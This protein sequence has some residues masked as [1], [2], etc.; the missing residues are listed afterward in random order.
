MYDLI[1][2]HKKLV[3]LVLAVI[4]LPFAFF[5][6][7]SYFTAGD[8]GGNFATVG[9]QP[10]TEQEFTLALQSRQNELQRMAGGRMDPALLDSSE[11]RFAVL[12]GI[13]RQ[14]LLVGQAVRSG[15]LVSDQQLQQIIG[16]Q[17]EFQEDG[18]FSRVRYETLLR[19]QGM[20]PVGF[21]N[22][23]RRDLMVERVSNAYR[24]TAI[25]P[26][27]VTERLLRI[28]AQQREV[29]Q[30]V[31]AP[32]NFVAQVKLE[33]GAAKQHYDAH[34]NE[35]QVPEQARLEYLVLA[36][37]ALAAQVEVSVDE[38]KQFYEQNLT[39]YARG[40]ER[41][42]SHILIAVDA[43]ASAE[44]KQAAR[45]KAEQLLQQARKNP[46][47]FAELARKNSQD[48]GSA[49]NGGDLGFFPRGAMTKPFDD[50]VFQMKAGEIAGPVESEF[51]YHVIR[52]IAVK[53]RG[54]EEVKQQVAL[55]LKRQKAARKFS[56]LGEQFNNLVFEQGESLKPAADALKLAI[57]SSSWVSRSGSENKLLNN[58]KLLQ[59]VFAED[60][61]RNKRNTEVVDVGNNTL[62]AAR[63]VE[64][65]PA[66]VRAFEEVS[67]GIAKR[68]ALQQAAQLA[69]ARGRELLA[70]LRQ[71][72][73]AAVTWGEPK[74]ISR[75]NP[76]GYSGPVLVGVLKTDVRKLPAY[77]GIENERSEFV[78]LKI[79]RVVEAEGVDAARLKAARE[80]LR[81]MLG[82][83]EFDAYVASLKLGTDI[84]VQKERLEKKER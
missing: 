38:V 44:E 2:S 31:L 46:A 32:E 33:A 53:G 18:K 1:Y 73:S 17:P 81:Q 34:Q 37:D 15:L 45:G 71:G 49:A 48:P 29:S 40:D 21:E 5:G 47:G 79:T 35:F 41:Q 27:A 62:V 42:A 59:A 10:I 66:S 69:A 51:G 61:I 55:D 50:A 13:V 56:E 82:Q 20:T 43:K 39:Q 52:L 63:V 3:Q 57:Q 78:L 72:E 54:L 25:V 67:A 8:R 36:L 80:E 75:E 14:R 84:K 76:Q 12:D 19:R 65:K 64:Y 83:E 26:N 30:S 70:K 28:N 58:Q 77:A 68:L 74:R 16:E 23:L 4:F 60:A 11:L 6:V 24:A 9:G 22:S 7:D